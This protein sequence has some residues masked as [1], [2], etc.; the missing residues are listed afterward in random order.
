MRV[1]S[2]CLSD[3][4][5][6]RITKSEKNG[7]HYVSLCITDRD[8]PND[9]GKDVNVSLSLGK[10]ERAAGVKPIYVGDGKNYA[11]P[12][13][14]AIIPDVVNNTADIDDLLGF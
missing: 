14:E 5:K 12:K 1:V 6:D 8:R 2:V 4:P 10:D 7:K 9:W 3:I 11:K 13:E